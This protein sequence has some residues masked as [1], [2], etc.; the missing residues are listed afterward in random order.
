MDELKH[1]GILGMKWGV[2]RFQ[3]PDGSLTFLGRLRYKNMEKKDAKWA[4]TKGIK[5]KEKLEKRL[6]GEASDYAIRTAGKL[7]TS[8]GKVSKTFIN[9]YN[10]KLAQ[11]MNERVG[12]ITSPSG[13]V[14]RFVAKRGDIGVFTA[15]ADV[16][17]NL[18]QFARGIHATGRIAY[19]KETVRKI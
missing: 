2:R 9:Q 4:K 12:N 7:K 14:L 19:K 3:N 8:S 13:K 17:A 18:D 1:Y 15:L 5:I 11:L 10:Q 6:S 16:D